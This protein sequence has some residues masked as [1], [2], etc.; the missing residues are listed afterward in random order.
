[1]TNSDGLMLV[2]RW[3]GVNALVQNKFRSTV[4]LLSQHLL[5]QRETPNDCVK[6][7]DIDLV[8]L[9]LTQKTFSNLR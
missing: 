4:H 9:L 8:S 3:A 6:S 7:V 1:M 5:A 2:C